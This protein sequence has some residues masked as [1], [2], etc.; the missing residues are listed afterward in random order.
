[1]GMEKYLA[2]V[3]AADIP[4]E[5]GTLRV[6]EFLHDHDCPKLTGGECGCDPDMVVGAPVPT[7]EE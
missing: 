4:R 3:F 2:K 6:I 1:M 5:P 7:P